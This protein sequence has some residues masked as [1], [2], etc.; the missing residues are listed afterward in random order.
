[1]HE[2]EKKINEEIQIT[3]RNYENEWFK[4]K[5]FNY[6]GIC[7][8]PFKYKPNN[9]R[10]LLFN[11]VFYDNIEKWKEHKPEIKEAI[12]LSHHTIPNATKILYL[13]GELISNINR[14]SGSK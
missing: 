11:T 9:K 10:D 5:N 14:P 6:D 7:S 2:S 13:Y 12:E 3:D 4:L 1:M 8:N